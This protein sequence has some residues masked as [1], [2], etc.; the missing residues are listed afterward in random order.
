MDLKNSIDKDI[1]AIDE[2]IEEITTDAYGDDEQ[3]WAFRQMIED[4]V[5]LPADG[6]IIDEPVKIIKIDYA[7]NEGPGLPQ[8]VGAMTAPSMSSVG[9]TSRFPRTQPIAG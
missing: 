8:P 9:R 4:E 5:D 6:F 2:L 7:G 1:A 3:L